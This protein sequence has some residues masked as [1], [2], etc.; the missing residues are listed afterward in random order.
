MYNKG[1]RTDKRDEV[2]DKIGKLSI[3]RE[4]G[5]EFSEKESRHESK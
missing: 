4:P 1:D 5:I 3:T 2:T